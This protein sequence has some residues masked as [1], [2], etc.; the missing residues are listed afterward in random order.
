MTITSLRQCLNKQKYN[1][2]RYHKIT[3]TGSFVKLTH[4][5][6]QYSL[7]LVEQDD[8]GGDGGG[9]G[10]VPCLHSEQ[11]FS[12]FQVCVASRVVCWGLGRTL[13]VKH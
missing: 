13:M 12:S 7:D 4:L 2:K 3:A 5:Q 8:E 10:D 9:D 6:R 11:V 1:T